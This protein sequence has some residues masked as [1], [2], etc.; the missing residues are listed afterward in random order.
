MT[1]FPLLFSSFSLMIK[2]VLFFPSDLV[3]LPIVNLPA[4]SI[5]SKYSNNKVIYSFCFFPGD[6]HPGV[7]CPLLSP[8]WLLNGPDAQLTSW[9]SFYHHLGKSCCP[10][11]LPHPLFPCFLLLFNFF[12]LEHT[13]VSSYERTCKSCF[14]RLVCIFS[15]WLGILVC[16]G[17]T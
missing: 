15:L 8:G 13:Q 6:L 9:A 1:I 14:L 3:S 16:R 4:S 5:I 2:I 10:L 7:L 12:L 11:L 17:P